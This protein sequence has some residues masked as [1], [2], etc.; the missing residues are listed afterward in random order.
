MGEA[1]EDP[2]L[3]T[4]AKAGIGA[5]AGA[6]AFL[7]AAVVFLLLKVR[8]N[9]KALQ[10]QQTSSQWPPMYQET[11]GRYVY[12]AGTPMDPWKQHTQTTMAQDDK[13]TV[14]GG[15]EMDARPVQQHWARVELSANN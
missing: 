2:G 12:Y 8:K 10:A 6:G 14:G 11:P 7:V 3:S 9:K 1:Q 15:Q 4:A 5:G 13:G